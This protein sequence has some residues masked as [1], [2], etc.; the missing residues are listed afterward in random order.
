MSSRKREEIIGSTRIGSGL[1]DGWAVHMAVGLPVEAV[2]RRRAR[3]LRLGLA[4]SLL[5]RDA[6]VGDPQVFVDLGEQETRVGD[7]RR[8]E[9]EPPSC[10]DPVVLLLDNLDRAT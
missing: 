7:H 10:D 3:W 4:G 5:G 8:I 6:A 2:D 1:D 9:V